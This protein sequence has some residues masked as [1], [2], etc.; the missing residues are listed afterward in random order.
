MPGSEETALLVPDLLIKI[1]GSPL[2]SEAK[3]DVLSASLQEDIEAPSMLTLQMVNWDMVNLKITWSDHNL[4]A[5]GNEVEIQMGYVDNLQKLMVGEITGLEPEFSADEIPRLTVR[6]YDRRHRLMRGRHTRS[7]TQVKD[8]D[9]ASQIAGDVGLTAQVEDSGVTLDYVLQHNQS[10]LQFLQQRALRIGYEVVVEEKTLHFRPRQ[11]DASEVLTLSWEKDLIEFH[12][13]L[14]S[15]GQVGQVAV[16]GWNPKDKAALVAEAAAG[17]E[18]STMGG[19]T[20]GPSEAGSAFGDSRYTSID[21]PVFSQ[22]EADKMAA[23]QFNDMALAYVS[24]EGIV[25]GRSELRA[26][27]VVKIEGLGDR[28]SGNYYVT[29]ASHTYSARE[30]YRTAFSVRR[31]A[32]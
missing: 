3:Q 13:R 1:N 31:N 22:A 30:G 7:F 24:G 5:V 16:R 32:I 6:G 26:G 9:I 17:S 25:A 19:S 12:P 18:S 29:A 21:W 10:D 23:G 27:T 8:S 4:M 14:T 15:L 28:F 11:N 20:S 2:P